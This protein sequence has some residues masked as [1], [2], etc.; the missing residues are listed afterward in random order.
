MI[1]DGILIPLLAFLL[2]LTL[3]GM[4]GSQKRHGK[5]TPLYAGVG[6][7]IAT[8]VGILVFMPIHIIGLISLVSA[9]I[10]DIVLLRKQPSSCKTQANNKE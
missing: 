5:T 4:K 10:W 3:W 2:S 7:A 9:S 6:G 1:S 8:L